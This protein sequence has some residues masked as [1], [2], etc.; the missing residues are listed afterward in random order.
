VITI[1]ACLDHL[2][3]IFFTHILFMLNSAEQQEVAVVESNALNCTHI[4]QN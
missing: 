2:W 3:V 4:N 1:I